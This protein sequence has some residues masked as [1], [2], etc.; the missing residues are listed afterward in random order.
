MCTHTYTHTHTHTHMHGLAHPNWLLMSCTCNWLVYPWPP[1]II[2]L[3]SHPI[4]SNSSIKTLVARWHTHTHTHTHAR[5][6][7]HTHTHTQFMYT[8]FTRSSRHYFMAY[9]LL[10]CR[11]EQPQRSLA[12]PTGARSLLWNSVEKKVRTCVHDLFSLYGSTAVHI[13]V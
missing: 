5:T 7:T 11:P 9:F 3:P 8:H 13:H 4:A 6:H 1:F 12:P 2:R 10:S